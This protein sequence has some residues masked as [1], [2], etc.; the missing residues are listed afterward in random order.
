MMRPRH[1]G[2]MRI[3]GTRFLFML[4]LQVISFPTR[5]G[6]ARECCSKEWAAPIFKSNLRFCADQILSLL[7]YCW[8]GTKSS[9]PVDIWLTAKPGH[10]PFCVLSVPLLRCRNRLL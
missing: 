3:W 10:L 8:F 9:D 1:A 7:L 6:A 2:S 5:V 4:L